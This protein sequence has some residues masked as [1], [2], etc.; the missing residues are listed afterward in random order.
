MVDKKHLLADIEWLTVDQRQGC[1]PG[2]GAEPI[3]G[4]LLNGMQFPIF[5]I[6]QILDSF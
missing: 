2:I 5:V 3:A 1:I 4:E 6:S